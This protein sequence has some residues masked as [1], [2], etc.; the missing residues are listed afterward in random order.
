MRR[1]RTLFTAISLVVLVALLLSAC[2]GNKPIKLSELEDEALMQILDEEGIIIPAGTDNTW[3]RLWLARLE[4]DP[5][6][7]ETVSNPKL[8]DFIDALRVIVIKY[9]NATP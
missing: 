3:V 4:A 7:P 2:S 1:K 9:G 8:I 5:D 6:F